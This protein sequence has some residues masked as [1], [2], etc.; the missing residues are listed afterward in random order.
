MSC[1]HYKEKQKGGSHEQIYTLFENLKKRVGGGDSVIIPIFQSFSYL[2]IQ[3]FLQSEQFELHKHLNHELYYDKYVV[4]GSKLDTFYDD[5][6]AFLPEITRNPTISPA[7]IT[8]TDLYSVIIGNEQEGFVNLQYQTDTYDHAIEFIHSDEFKTFLSTTR[9]E[10]DT[11]YIVKQPIGILYDISQQPF[12]RIT[13]NELIHQHEEDVTWLHRRDEQ[14]QES[15]D[16]QTEQE[17]GFEESYRQQQQEWEQPQEIATDDPSR[18][19]TQ[20]AQVQ[21][22]S[23]H[24]TLPRQLSR[25]RPTKCYDSVDISEKK[26]KTHLKDDNNLVVFILREDGNGYNAECMT[27]DQLHALFTDESSIYYE[28]MQTPDE[29]GLFHPLND[30]EYANHPQLRKYVK[31]PTAFGSFLIFYDDLL[32][33]YQNLQNIIFIQY[34]RTIRLTISHNVSRTGNRISGYHCQDGS[35]QKLYR[36]FF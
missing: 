33:K 1:R 2:K 17:P 10:L 34:E 27:F 8:I 28:C 21:G 24:P 5:H 18:Q 25:V 30:L 6:L 29:E 16:F 3:N 7:R 35:E 4:V 26:I 31:L 14:D 12:T 11:I 9:R 15:D 13:R 32:D 23:Q 19:L 20:I 22:H 36:I